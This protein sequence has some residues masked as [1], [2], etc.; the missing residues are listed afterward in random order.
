MLEAAVTLA[1]LVREFEFDAPP[2]EVALTADLL[3]H[4]AGEVPCHLHRCARA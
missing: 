3:L 1:T 2:G 4:P